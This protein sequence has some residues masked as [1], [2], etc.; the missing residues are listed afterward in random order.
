MGARARD[1]R[2]CADAHTRQE[3]VDLGAESLEAGLQ[4][5]VLLE[6]VASPAP[7]DELPLQIVNRDGYRDPAVRIEVLERDRGDVGQVNLG[8]AGTAAQA[9]PREI[10]IEIEH[11]GTLDAI[12]SVEMKTL[13]SSVLCSSACMPSSLPT[14][15]CL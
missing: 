3:E 11:R 9:D 2:L 15:D 14:P 6:A 5:Q 1:A 4:Q 13:F 10:R 7:G 8:D 12:Y